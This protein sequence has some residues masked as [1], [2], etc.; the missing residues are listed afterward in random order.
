M[1][2]NLDAV[3]RYRVINKC[4]RNKFKT[5]PT[6]D[7]L[8]TACEEALGC[9]ISERT[10]DKDLNEMRFN[11]SLGYLAPIK[12]DR[13]TKGYSYED[14]NYSIDAIP[15]G[16]S[17]LNAIEFAAEI[18]GQ[19]KNVN[20]LNEFKG[21]VDKIVDTVKVQRYIYD[22]PTLE[23]V[24]QLDN[25]DYVPGSEHLNALIEGIKSHK[26]VQLN[27]KKFGTDEPKKYLFCPYILKEYNGLWYVTG[28]IHD[29][30]GIRTFALDR[31]A[32]ISSDGEFYKIDPDF[33][34]EVYYNNVFGVTHTNENPQEV[35]L[36]T[37]QQTARY[38]QIM[39]IHKSQELIKEEGA[40]VWFSL[41]LVL[42]IELE[43]KILSLG[44]GCI[45]ESP[46]QLKDAVKARLEKA[47]LNYG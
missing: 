38:L 36:K 17:D 13:K 45:V 44:D 16:K 32:E 34:R 11:E 39:P 15:I 8:R 22:E 10:I 41:K 14:P 35:I 25:L 4:L 27:Y 9:D 42:N 20:I 29:G 24:V 3:I 7:E 26:V 30:E 23:G 21:A 43:T 19:Y 31:I 5:Y 33:D 2:K 18:L 6:Q 37:E 28:K 1:S 46:S 40:F 12:Y 47:M